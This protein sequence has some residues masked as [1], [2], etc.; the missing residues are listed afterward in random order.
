MN[1]KKIQSEQ[2]KKRVADAARNLFANKGYK[3][4]SI[5]DIVEATGS[6]KGNIYY[7]FKSKEGLFLYLLD[8]WD[9]EWEQKWV[10]KESLYKTTKEKLFGMAEQMVL[11]DLNHPLTKAAD[12]FF[13][14]EEKTG[15]IEERIAEMVM[16]H[17]K[18]NQKLIQQ[19][20]DSGEFKKEDVESLAIILES[21]LIGLS[22]MSR[23]STVEEALTLYKLAFNVF[24]FGI[25]TSSNR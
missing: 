17:L 20:I 16:G 8:E 11:D 1:K 21:L 22:Q 2:T 12:E 15:E 13:N 25:S 14:N 10:E 5:E 7:H 24:L 4:T 3:A 9:K 19:G 18:F 6:S 23:K